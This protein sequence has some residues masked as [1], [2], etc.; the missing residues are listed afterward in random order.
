MA[1]CCSGDGSWIASVHQRYRAV[2]PAG[3]HIAVVEVESAGGVLDRL[4][5]HVAQGPAGSGA[6]R[7]PPADSARRPFRKDVGR[8][9][10]S[11]SR[12][13]LLVPH[14]AGSPNTIQRSFNQKKK[15]FNSRKLGPLSTLTSSSSDYLID[16]TGKPPS[17]IHRL[18]RNVNILYIKI[19][20]IIN[21]L[22]IYLSEKSSIY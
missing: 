21:K 12:P 1:G 6:E 13:R 5:R 3:H 19:L 8:Q 17:E 4:H 14:P 15:S 10:A 11:P 7:R 22:I 18:T 20:L 16:F 9:R 2:P